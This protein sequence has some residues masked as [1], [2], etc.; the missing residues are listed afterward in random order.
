MSFSWYFQGQRLTDSAHYKIRRGRSGSVLNVLGLAS[1]AGLYSC[2]ARSLA[3]TASLNQSLLV[4]G[5]VASLCE[6]EY[7][8]NGASCSVVRLS[9]G[10]LQ[11]VCSCR[12]GF[13]GRRCELKHVTTSSIS[14]SIASSIAIPL[15]IVCLASLTVISL[16]IVIYYFSR[17]LQQIDVILRQQETTQRLLSQR[18]AAAKTESDPTARP[19]VAQHNFHHC[20]HVK[21]RRGSGSNG[22]VPAVSVSKS[23]SSPGMTAL[24]SSQSSLQS[25]PGAPETL[26]LELAPPSPPSPLSPGLSPLYVE[27][28]DGLREVC[29][30]G[31][32]KHSQCQ[33]CLREADII[34]SQCHTYCS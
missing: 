14:S 11:P 13:T 8:L 9:P 21:A 17:R 4:H 7:C 26:R 1:T 19:V 27:P 23:A 32:E 16:L 5:T 30:H 12:E 3:G 31:T 28:W 18:L 29:V 34:L 24:T 2:E 33:G 20:G 10:D 25:R 6:A 15:V 22:C